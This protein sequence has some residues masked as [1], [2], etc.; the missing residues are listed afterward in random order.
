LK[1]EIIG[2]QNKRSAPERR[3]AAAGSLS[4][5]NNQN[6]HRKKGTDPA[7]IYSKIVERYAML[8]ENPV[9]RLRFL[10]NTLAKQRERQEHLRNS[11]SRFQFLENT[12]FYDWVL[13]ARF[14]SA[15]LEELQAVAPTLPVQSQRAIER[16]QVPF[17]AR[18]Y[19]FVHQT[20]HAFYALGVLLAG[21]TL[22][23]LYLMA[24]WSARGVNAYFASKYKTGKAPIIV[25]AGGQGTPNDFTP[26]KY[27][28]QPEKVWLV[29]RTNEHER[30]SNGCRILTK[31][32]TENHPRGYYTI[33]RGS[34]TDGEVER[35]DIA[36]IVYHTSESDIVPFIP[37]NND[38]IQRRSM[39]L[40]DWIRQ[41]KS[42]NYLID[43]YGEIYRVV[44]D[45]HAAHHS[46]NSIW[47]DSKYNYVGLN[48]SFL[49]ICFES[50]VS[51]GTLQETLTEAQIGA[52]RTLTNVLRSKYTID[53][54]N[55]TTHGLV[56]V[57]PD[58]MLIAFHHDWVRNFPFEAMGLSDKYKVHPPNMSDY[59]FIYDEETLEKLGRTLWPGAIAAEEEFNK[60]SE[61]LHINA[62][63]LRR[64]WRD[65]YVAQMEKARKLHAAFNGDNK[66]IIAKQTSGVVEAA[67]TGSNN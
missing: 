2:L 21:A 36:G 62:E 38:S 6:G 28:Y 12:R 40:L 59:G 43:R 25:N 66:A 20:R 35:H 26:A 31:Y 19:T 41:K 63:V 52:G 48:E 3:D 50:T 34:E 29:E 16:L 23:G 32:E 39:G 24:S 9:A 5:Q 54:A 11:L 49:G 44:R 30:Y 47:A 58:K 27:G 18:A 33:P 13:E 15:I 42:Y 1:T 8:F 60:R 4:N 55:C 22:F 37:D 53:D 45:D 65:R 56:S 61:K 17:S 14:Y 57:N 10:N 67:E 64:R 7:Q 46:G 51:A